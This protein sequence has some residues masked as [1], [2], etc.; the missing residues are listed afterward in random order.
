MNQPKQLP[1]LP[2]QTRLIA[3]LDIKGE[4]LI[5][6]IQL[7]GLRVVGDPQEKALKYY[8]DG[9]DEIIYMD[10]VAS[11][12]GRNNLRE[13]VE[14]TAQNIFVPF[15]VGGGVRSVED[16]RALLLAGADK[17][18]INTAAIGNPELIG[19]IAKT[20]GA[21]CAVLSIEAKKI[22]GFKWECYTDNGRESTGIDVLEWTK[23][24]QSLGVGEILLTSIDN[25]GT[26]N[27]F[28]TDLIRCVSKICDVP[29]VV[30]GGMGSLHD[31]KNVSMAGCVDGIAMA[32]VLHFNE[33]SVQEIR[34]A[35]VDAGLGMR[36]P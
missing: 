23:R 18:A 33:L 3:R 34:E 15:T 17:I 29:L 7:E 26:R 20:F 6:T 16:A 21:Q 13:I 35:A 5:K 25:E 4:N 32:H 12:Y 27:G 14:Y 36:K 9:I 28:D 24:A 22:D 8:D 1:D 2:Q 10:I 11:L 31:I 30:S 19:A